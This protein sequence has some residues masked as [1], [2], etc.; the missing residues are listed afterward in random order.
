MVNHVILAK[1]LEVSNLFQLNHAHNIS[2]RLYQFHTSAI[3]LYVEWLKGIQ[4]TR[5]GANKELFP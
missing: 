1:H 5:S 3:Y 2:Q 4:L